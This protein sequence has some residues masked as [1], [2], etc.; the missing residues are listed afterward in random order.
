MSCKIDKKIILSLDGCEQ[1]IFQH[2]DNWASGEPRIHIRIEE[3]ASKHGYDSSDLNDT[4]IMVIQKDL[5]Y[6]DIESLKSLCH[7][8]EQYL[9]KI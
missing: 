1:I 4:D 3:L 7:C 9:D 8:L 5:G 6:T 2:L